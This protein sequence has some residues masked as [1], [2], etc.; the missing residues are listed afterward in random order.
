MDESIRL[1]IDI[2]MSETVHNLLL[3]PI[4]SCIYNKMVTIQD[5]RGG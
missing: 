3:Y 2:D 5:L 1:K 4:K